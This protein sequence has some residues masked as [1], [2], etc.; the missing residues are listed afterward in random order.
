MALTPEQC[1]AARALLDWTQDALAARAGISRGTIRGFEG[2]QH[3]LQR[4]TATAVRRALEE[5]GVLLL[6]AGNGLGQGVRLAAAPAGTAAADT[7]RE[8]P[9]PAATDAR[10]E[11]PLP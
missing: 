1:R 5:A 11:T 3:A 7:R 6:E 8:T 10:P 2:G 9:G 4:A